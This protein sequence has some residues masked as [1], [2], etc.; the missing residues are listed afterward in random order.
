MRRRSGT[1]LRDHVDSLSHDVLAVGGRN[2]DR[3]P[4][5][6]WRYERTPHVFTAAH[7]YIRPRLAP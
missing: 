5:K 3:P 4:P 2:P 1:L 7:D 6:S